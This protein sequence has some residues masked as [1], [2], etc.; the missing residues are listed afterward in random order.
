LVEFDK[1]RK[2]LPSN[3]L[4]SERALIF[5]RTFDSAEVST[6]GRLARD[7]GLRP[8]R[9]TK[10][11]ALPL[12]VLAFSAGA[13]AGGFLGELG[14]D[15]YK[16]GKQQVKHL[17]TLMNNRRR[18]TVL[19]FQFE[20]GREGRPVQVEIFITNPKG[21]DIQHLLDLKVQTI[22]ESLEPLISSHESVKVVAEYV[23]RRLFPKFSMRADGVPY[24][25]SGSLVAYSG[26]LPNGISISFQN[27]K[28]ER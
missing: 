8:V 14:K 17:C 28:L 7:L 12:A 6:I 27:E 11:A 18:E 24:D 23:H 20:I 15:L 19:L 21:I 13:V 5:D 4:F 1:T 25:A 16:F 9:R 10:K 2:R 22:E 3:I 26:D